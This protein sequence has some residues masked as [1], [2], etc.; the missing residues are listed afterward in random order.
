MGRKIWECRVSDRF[1]SSLSSGK[2]TVVPEW[3]QVQKVVVL[4]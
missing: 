3:V 4:S 2:E 1:L